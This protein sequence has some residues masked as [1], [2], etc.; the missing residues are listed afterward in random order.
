MKKI[1]FVLILAV[2]IFGFS[3]FNLTDS[4]QSGSSVLYEQSPGV[5]SELPTGITPC[6]PGNGVQCEIEIDGEMEALWLDEG[7]TPYKKK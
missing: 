7:I 1:A 5:F 6:P 4:S 2:S 3:A